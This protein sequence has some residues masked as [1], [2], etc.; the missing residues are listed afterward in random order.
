MGTVSEKAH[1]LSYDACTFE[2]KHGMKIAE[3]VCSESFNV[4]DSKTLSYPYERSLICVV[5][6]KTQSGVAETLGTVILRFVYIC[7]LK[8]NGARHKAVCST[9]K[10]KVIYHYLQLEAIWRYFLSDCHLSVAS[11]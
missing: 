7:A 3:E 9:A 2:V 6:V 4:S 1:F 8:T 10:L 11:I 5:G